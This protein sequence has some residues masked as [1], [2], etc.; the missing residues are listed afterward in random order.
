ML[1]KVKKYLVGFFLFVFLFPPVT[2]II[3]IN[4]HSDDIH[5]SERN[6]NHFHAE[7]HHCT[8]CDYSSAPSD[9]FPLDILLTGNRI[10]SEVIFSFID[11]FEFLKHDFNLALRGPPSAS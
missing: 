7:E 4:K 2:E 11:K 8:I 6:V 5:C 10:F 3:H 9:S 1:I